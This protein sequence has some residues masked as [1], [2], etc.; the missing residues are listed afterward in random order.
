MAKRTK[1]HCGSEA[2]SALVE[3]ALM[4]PIMMFLLVAV[5]ELPGSHMRLLRFQTQPRQ[6]S[7]MALR[8]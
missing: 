1:Q 7:N 3:L 6:R 5:L 8:A 2:G 4:M